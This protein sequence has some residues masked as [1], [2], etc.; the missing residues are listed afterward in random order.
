VE[1]IG[2]LEKTVGLPFGEE[3]LERGIGGR[4]FHGDCFV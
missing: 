4:E 1:E 2:I 3:G